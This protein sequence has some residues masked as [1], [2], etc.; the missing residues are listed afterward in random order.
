MSRQEV[1]GTA[2]RARRFNVRGRVQGVGFRY[3]TRNTARRLGLQGWVRNRSDG[4]V[5]VWAQGTA[6]ALRHL[7]VFLG[8]GPRGARVESVATDEVEPD[9]AVT[10]FEVAY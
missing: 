5:E 1:P 7:D 9:R 3:T 8:S 6:E 10:G 4:S 2:P